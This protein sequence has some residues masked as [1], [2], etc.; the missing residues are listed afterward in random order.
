MIFLAAIWD[1]FNVSKKVVLEQHRFWDAETQPGRRACTECWLTFGAAVP[2]LGRC[3]TSSAA[4][5]GLGLCQLALLV[6]GRCFTHL[7]VSLHKRD[8]AAALPALWDGVC[9]QGKG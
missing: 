7:N 9:A 4:W 6:R 8:S 3:R 5:E 1:V 2:G